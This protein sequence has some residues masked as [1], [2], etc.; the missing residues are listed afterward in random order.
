MSDTQ[1]LFDKI[2]TL[3]KGL[4]GKKGKPKWLFSSKFFVAFGSIIAIYL[5]GDKLGM[6]SFA[7]AAVACVFMIT[8]AYVEVA[9]MR[10]AQE[11]EAM[12]AKYAMEDGKV[13][14]EEVAALNSMLVRNG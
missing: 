5:L 8:R 4:K 10:L 12:L 2:E 13:S 6:I 7:A 9:E 3:Y 11:R 1:D 14:A